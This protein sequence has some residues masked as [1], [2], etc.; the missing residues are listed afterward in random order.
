MYVGTQDSNYLPYNII[1][2]FRRYI[3]PNYSNGTE[4]KWGYIQCCIDKAKTQDPNLSKQ[5]VLFSEIDSTNALSA[6]E[7]SQF[8][9]AL[10]QVCNTLETRAAIDKWLR[11]IES[12][13]K[14][15]MTANF[16][17]DL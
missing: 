12:E 7:R 4:N 9:C 14:L 16:I 5:R 1:G 10:T 11:E 2:M 17:D 3:N 8:Y 6:E 15:L 13:R